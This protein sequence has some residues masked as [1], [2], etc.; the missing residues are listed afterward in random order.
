MSDRMPTSRLDLGTRMDNHILSAF[1][2][3]FPR[4]FVPQ[5]FINLTWREVLGHGI[6]L[7]NTGVSST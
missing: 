3:I 4:K 7:A 5:M 6:K 2:G 1:L